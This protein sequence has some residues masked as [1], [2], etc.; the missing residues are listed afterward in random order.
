VDDHLGDNPSLKS[1]LDQALRTAYRS[2]ANEASIEAGLARS[3]FPAECRY[4]YEQV[5]NLDFWPE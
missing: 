3:S 5:M 4:S 1:Q 2:A